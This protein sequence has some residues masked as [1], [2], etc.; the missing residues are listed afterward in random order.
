M[1]RPK[2]DCKVELCVVKGATLAPIRLL[3]IS[4]STM[5]A[6]GTQHDAP[7]QPAVDLKMAT[8]IILT[9]PA[10]VVSKCTVRET[11]CTDLYNSLLSK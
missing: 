9:H 5:M 11:K 2:G 8:G 7:Y 6:P 10:M 1:A 4:Y 3:F